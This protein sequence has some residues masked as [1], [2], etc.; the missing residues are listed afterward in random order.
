M[1][2]GFSICIGSVGW[3][4]VMQCMRHIMMDKS[5]I[6]NK[7]PDIQN[8]WNVFGIPK[9]LVID[10]GK[11]FKNKAMKD[12]ALQCGFELQYC[13]PRTPEWKA[14]IERYFGTMNRNLIHN[15]PGTT[16]S[17]PQCLSE[18]ENPVKM[19]KIGFCTFLELVH[20][21][22][23]DVY[24]QTYNKGLKGVPAKVWDKGV[25]EHRPSWPNDA[26]ELA[27]LLG[28][29]EERKITRRGIQLNNLYYN[30]TELN[31]LLHKLSKY[32]IDV[33]VKVKYDPYDISHV[34]V[35]DNFDNSR[36]LKIPSISLEYTTDLT[37]MEHIE[38]CK[39]TREKLGSVDE[40]SL[41]KAKKYIYDKVE[42]NI[43][44]VQKLKKKRITSSYEILQE[45]DTNKFLKPLAKG[46]KSCDNILNLGYYYNTIIKNDAILITA[47][48]TKKDRIKNKK[49]SNNHDKHNSR[50]KEKQVIRNNENSIADVNLDD[51]RVI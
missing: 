50:K 7:Y 16:R 26:S 37:E 11:E 46:K 18:A 38:I 19:A 34:Y 6:K 41:A 2:V 23:V 4:E 25:A 39:L 42:D 44:F 47:K 22:I 15:L 9:T 36:W 8:D 1:I 20:K 43:E 24:S 27:I 32:D 5:Y 10:N 12:A 49:I 40:I 14:S 35:L 48:T 33:K 30:S 45:N 51:F 3:P 28:K 31:H 13:P 29:V 17:N 21:W